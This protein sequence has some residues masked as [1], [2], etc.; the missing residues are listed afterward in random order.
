MAVYA[1]QVSCIDQ[2]IGKLL[3][4]LEKQGKTK[5]TLIIFLSDNGACPEP[6]KELGGGAMADINNKEKWGAISYGEGWANVSST[7]FRKWKRELEEGGMA[8]PFIMYWPDGIA[9][10]MQDKLLHT[11]SFLPDVMP[12]FLEVSGAS[13]PSSYHNNTIY[14]LEGRSMAPLLKGKAINAH[15]YMCWEHEGNQAILKGDWKAV[16]DRGKEWELFDL[17][18][19]RTEQH[20]LAAQHPD[21]LKELTTYW[22]QWADTHFVFPKRPSSGSQTL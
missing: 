15:D 22:Q 6:Y 8:A 2:N 11:P 13:Y 20:N 7:P 12:T 5:N 18:A 9:A 3:A 1:A 16:K 17:S 10:N 19:D 14:P 21:L 4:T